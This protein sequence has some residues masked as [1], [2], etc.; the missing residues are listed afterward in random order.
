MSLTTQLLGQSTPISGRRQSLSR[1][2]S[3]P[4]TGKAAVEGTDSIRPI[5]L[6][7]YNLFKVPSPN[8]ILRHT[9]AYKCDIT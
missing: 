3:F 6:S 7:S 5:N 8:G 9:T 4:E 2:G 1:T